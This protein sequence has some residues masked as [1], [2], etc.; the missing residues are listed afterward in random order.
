MVLVGYTFNN[1][2]MIIQLFRWTLLRF[3]LERINAG[4]VKR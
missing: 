4:L 3:D 1:F 2:M